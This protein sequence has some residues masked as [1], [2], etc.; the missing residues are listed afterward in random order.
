[1][2]RTWTKMTTILFVIA[3]S[4]AHAEGNK[5]ID[6][7]CFLEGGGHPLRFEGTYSRTA[8]SNDEG[9]GTEKIDT[10]GGKRSKTIF[11]L[12]RGIDGKGPGTLLIYTE[13]ARHRDTQIPLQRF[14][15][16]VDRELRMFLVLQD[17]PITSPV[18][19]TQVRGGTCSG[20]F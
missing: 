13:P 17:D 3:M 19:Y 1:M 15:Y 8:G 2:S 4:H 11:R 5:K 16:Q 18:P 7:R 6:L 14:I 12:D 10:D 9:V 20:S